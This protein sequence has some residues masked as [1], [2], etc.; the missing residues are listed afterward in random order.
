MAIAFVAL[1]VAYAPVFSTNQTGAFFK[2]SG[3]IALFALISGPFVW[4]MYKTPAAAEN[5]YA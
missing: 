5:I 2:F 1:L 3:L 4:T